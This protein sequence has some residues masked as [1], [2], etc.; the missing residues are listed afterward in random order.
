MADHGNN[1]VQH[2]FPAVAT[3]F[4]EADDHPS[5]FLRPMMPPSDAAPAAGCGC[6]DLDELQVVFMVLISLVADDANLFQETLLTILL[7]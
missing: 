3:A 5:M 7:T 2:R 4:L 6:S 1:Q